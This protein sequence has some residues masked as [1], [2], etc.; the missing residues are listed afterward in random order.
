MKPHSQQGIAQATGGTY[1][2]A[3]SSEGLTASLTTATT[4]T[5]VSFQLPAQR[6]EFSADTTKAPSLD[7]GT[8][9]NSA[10]YHAE[11]T[12]PENENAYAKI[13]VPEGHWLHVGFNTVPPLGTKTFLEDHY[14][15]SFSAGNCTGDIVSASDLTIA[16]VPA[17]TEAG[18]DTIE[19]EIVEGETQCLVVPIKWG[20][21]QPPPSQPNAPSQHRTTTKPTG[22]CP[23]TSGHSFSP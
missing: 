1:S 19:A 2:D 4:R 22:Y 15:I 6:V 18:D 16:A 12:T 20:Q 7:V 21:A 10:H 13:T 9:D 5:A 8:L 14:G 11:I 17:P 23:L 3:A